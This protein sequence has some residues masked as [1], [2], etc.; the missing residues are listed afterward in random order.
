MRITLVYVDTSRMFNLAI[1]MMQF[2]SANFLYSVLCCCTL[3]C[4]HLGIFRV[5]L[6]V[7]MHIISLVLF[8]VKCLVAVFSIISIALSCL[9]IYIFFL[10]FTH[11]DSSDQL[12]YVCLISHITTV[13]IYHK[14]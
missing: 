9:Y 1:S 5:S 3:Q 13:A 10:V 6:S 7:V 4:F 11:L 2:V 14:Q 8:C 12:F